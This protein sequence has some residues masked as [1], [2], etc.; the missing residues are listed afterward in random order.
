MQVQRCNACDDISIDCKYARVYQSA[1]VNFASG[2]DAFYLSGTGYNSKT[3]SCTGV[4]SDFT[5][6]SLSAGNV[7]S[8]TLA[9]FCALPNG[10][11]S[12]LAIIPFLLVLGHVTNDT[13]VLAHE[14]DLYFCSSFSSPVSNH[15]FLILRVLHLRPMWLFFS[16]RN[17]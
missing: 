8:V 13:S 6:A 11:H 4:H 16:F 14:K 9:I 3:G 17:A 2:S 5:N 10:R 7:R 15:T 1:Y 12:N